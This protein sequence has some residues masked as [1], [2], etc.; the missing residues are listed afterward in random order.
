MCKNR[1]KLT[2]AVAI[3]LIICSV[4]ILLPIGIN[5]EKTD[6]RISE[7]YVG[8][9]PFG[10]KLYTD[11]LLVVG[12]DDIETENGL[13]CPAAD[14]GIKLGDIIIELNGNK[15]KNAEE[16]TTHIAESNT[17]VQLK[18]MR[19]ANTVTLKAS[20]K[21]SLTDNKKHLG[22][23]LRDSAAGI[24]TVTFKVP[25]SNSFAGLGHG[26]CDSETG[27]ILPMS[28]GTLSNVTI[29]GV[30]KGEVGIP[31]ELKGNFTN[32]EIGK[33]LKNTKHGLFGT[34]N[35]VTESAVLSGLVK[36]GKRSEIKDGEA[37]IISTVDNNGPQKYTVNI[38]T[39][40]SSDANFELM[41]TDAE[42]ISKTGGI[43]R[44]MSGSP[45]IQN[46][47]L[48]GAVTHVLVNNPTR[49]YG[50]FIEEMLEAAGNSIN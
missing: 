13:R 21:K 8:G 2:R 5:A 20:P 28:N 9:E 6:T 43:V 14:A 22:L 29:T 15:V 23:W 12:F 47:K 3:L 37:Y 4:V 18:I 40:N 33:V 45:I 26:I 11:G 16:F 17:E 36:I 27:E 44:G 35:T 24:G 25:E 39:S 41:V 32:D 7:V 1:F 46:G 48:V 42:L 30:K 19:A 10:V 49:G 31:G 50:I 38:C 34:I